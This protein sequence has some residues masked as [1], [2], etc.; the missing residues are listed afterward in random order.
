MKLAA[1]A[2]A[3]GASYDWEWSSDGGKTWTQ[4]PSTLQAKTT[5]SCLPVA[6]TVLFRFR[7]VVK[8]GEADW[9][10]PISFVVK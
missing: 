4:V 9:C 8:T 2:A 7:S 1:K 6:T 3:Q 5:I 10:Q